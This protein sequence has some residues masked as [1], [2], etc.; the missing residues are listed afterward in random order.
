MLM[1]DRRHYCLLL[2]PIWMRFLHWVKSSPSERASWHKKLL[3]HN[4]I[5]CILFSFDWSI[6]WMG[7]KLKVFTNEKFCNKQ[8]FIR[9]K[10][11][12][13]NKLFDFFVG[14]KSGKYMTIFKEDIYCKCVSILGRQIAINSA[15]NDEASDQIL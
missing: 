7:A 1:I 2:V 10:N 4:A 3:W 15:Q 11:S 9:Q 14:E 13:F 5:T 6:P 8:Y 12:D